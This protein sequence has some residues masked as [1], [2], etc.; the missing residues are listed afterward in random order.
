MGF[1]WQFIKK[2]TDEVQNSLVEGE[3]AEKTF[4]ETAANPAVV[5]DSGFVM[6]GE[7][8]EATYL[9]KINWINNPDGTVTY[10]GEKYKRNAHVK[11]ILCAGIDKNKSMQ[12]TSENDYPGN[13][14]GIF[15]I[16][17]D[18][19]DNSVRIFMIPRDS[20]AECEVSAA[21]EN[22]RIL[23]DHL[24]VS[25]GMG[26]G[27]KTSAE[28]LRTT[29]SGLLCNLKI[30]NYLI[31]DIS[32]LAD[33][34]DMVGGV[35]VTVPNDE[36]EKVN[37][38]WTTGRRIVLKGDEAER[39]L[40]HRNSDDEGS[41]V[42]RMGQHE[43]YISGFYNALKE[44]SRSD[45]NIVSRLA[46]KVDATILSDMSKGEYE[47]LAIDGIQSDFN[48][49]DIFSFPGTMTVG[50]MDGELY[51]EVYLDYTQVIPMLL[52]NFYRKTE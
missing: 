26:D 6:S 40:R 46:D 41:P 28:I 2:N 27:G 24:S 20:M 1:F 25:F 22:P 9:Y 21:D 49:D 15:L 50:E 5:A 12:Y 4:K 42:T 11:A 44:K 30:D 52:E 47:K 8:W 13:A 17:H 51:D 39:F 7:D 3:I 23:F 37:P 31:G 45:S 14:D 38:E 19:S 18:T 10:N 33:V 35:E 29:A 34:N 36:L 48:S 16:A 32:L 43:Q